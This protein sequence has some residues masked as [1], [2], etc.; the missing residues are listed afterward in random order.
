MA[1]DSN[2]LHT[3]GALVRCFARH[4]IAAQ[5]LK[6]PSVIADVPERA[7]VVPDWIL[8]LPAKRALFGV[9]Q[10]AVDQL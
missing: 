4:S 7:R 1:R 2:H 3:S 6:V 5:W 9:I 10:K 8:A